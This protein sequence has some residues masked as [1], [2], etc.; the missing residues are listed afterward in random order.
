MAIMTVGDVVRRTQ[1]LLDDPAGRRFSK[2]YLTP[3]IDQENEQLQIFLEKLGVQQE[4]QT[5]IFNVPAATAGPT[6]L[7]P[8]FA[9]GQPLEY[10]MRPK[11]LHWK[12]QSQPDTAYAQSSLVEE[13]T[14]VTPGNVGCQQYRWAGGAIQTTPSYTAV[15]LR[16]YFYALSQTVYD[17][18]A[19]VMR[20]IGGLL[21]LSTADLVCG[22]NNDMGKLG[23]KVQ[24]KLGQAKR[25]FSGLLT[26]QKQAQLIVPR[27]TKRG[28]GVQISAGGTRY[29]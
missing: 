27:G 28:G 29:I 24:K 14:D 25:S 12:L 3:L 8:Y 10:F 16:V 23:A 2:A 6:D 21:A 26:M 5:A 22:L 20:G 18:S 1:A 4:E 9:P 17:D 11:Q 15:T 7:T 13:L 19:K